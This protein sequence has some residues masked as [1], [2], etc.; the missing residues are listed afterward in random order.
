MRILVLVPTDAHRFTA[1]S[2]IRYDRLNQAGDDFDIVVQS[3]EAFTSA[4][5]EA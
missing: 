5:L 1:G 2:R 3:L 4:D